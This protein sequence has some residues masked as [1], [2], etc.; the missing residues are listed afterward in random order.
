MSQTCFMIQ[1]FGG[2]FDKLFEDIFDPAVRSGGLIPYR[3][4]R[5]MSSSI[6]IESIERGIRS[7]TICFADLSIDNP[8]VWFELGFAIA[9]GKDLCLV[10]SDERVKYPFDVQH[11]TVISYSSESPRDFQTLR[12]AITDRIAALLE[13]QKNITAVTLPAA[14]APRSG[15]A[16]HEIACIAAIASEVSGLEMHLSNYYLKQE[17]ERMG[18]NAL[19]AQVGLRSL[20]KQGYISIHRET[21]Q[22]G[23]AYEVYAL[24]DDGWDWVASNVDQLNIRKSVRLRRSLRQEFGDG[25][26]DKIPF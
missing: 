6:P 10:C 1:P 21:D 24:T 16:S 25:L 17:M 2:R 22:D 15:L 8:N 12:D 13:K 20:L 4:D 5:D 3:V 14:T 18:Y 7:A 23:D 26:D 11:R 9:E 19:A